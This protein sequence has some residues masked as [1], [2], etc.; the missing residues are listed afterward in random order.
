M[1][2]CIATDEDKGFG[3]KASDMKAV[4]ANIDAIDDAALSSM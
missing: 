3:Q 2:N 1:G 4:G